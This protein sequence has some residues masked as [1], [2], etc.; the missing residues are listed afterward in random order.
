MQW[1]VWF[2]LSFTDMRKNKWVFPECFVVCKKRMWGL[3]E[4]R[5]FGFDTLT[6][7]GPKK[8]PGIRKREQQKP[9]SEGCLSNPYFKK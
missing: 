1:F 4:G 5:G 6:G 2:G 8:T 7:E 3:K 9:K